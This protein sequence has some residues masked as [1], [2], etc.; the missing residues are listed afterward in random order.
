MNEPHLT[1]EKTGSVGA[2]SNENEEGVLDQNYGYKL[3]SDDP[4]WS[5][6]LEEAERYDDMMIKKWDNF[7][8][9]S[10]QDLRPDNAA[11][12]ATA[13]VE[14]VGI[15]QNRTTNGQQEHP[16]P[17]SPDNFRPSASTFIVN[18][19]WFMSLWLSI[20]VALLAGLVKQWCSKFLWDRTAP[21]CKQ[22][23]IRQAR[24]NQLIR[25][26]MDLAVY[27][28][29]VVMDTALGLFLLGLLIFLQNLS[30]LMFLAALGLT[31]LT[32]AFYFGT[33]FAPFFVSF[34]PY[35]T[36]LSSRKI[37]G[38]LFQ[39]CR[40]LCRKLVY[41]TLGIWITVIKYFRD[42]IN[43]N[44]IDAAQQDPQI[45]DYTG[46]MFACE[47][48]EIEISSKTTPDQLTG[49]ALK[50]IILH[51]QKPE[52]RETAIRAIATLESEEALTQLVSD[53]P[54]IILRVIQSFTSCFVVNDIK[55]GV[56]IGFR[57]PIDADLATL[58]GR[59]LTVLVTRILLKGDLIEPQGR[60][61]SHRGDLEAGYTHLKWA[62]DSVTKR[63]V[64]T[65]FEH[66]ANKSSNEA[67]VWA[68][69]GSSVWCDF[70]GLSGGL[71][72]NQG[73]AVCELASTLGQSLPSILRKEVLR[74]LTKEISYWAPNV[75]SRYRK[76]ILRHLIDLIPTA[77]PPEQPQLA[78][79]LVV[80]AINLN[81]GASYILLPGYLNS[82]PEVPRGEGPCNKFAEE[83]ISYYA[84]TPIELVKDEQ[85]LLLFALTGLM[86]YYEH[87]DFDDEAQQNMKKVAAR[88]QT[89]DT[90]GKL[91]S[92]KIPLPSN[93]DMT[94]DLRAYFTNTLLIYLKM[95]RTPQHCQNMDEVLTHLLKAIN[96]KRQ[97][98]ELEEYGPQIV[99]LVTQILVQTED[100]ELQTQ[101][102]STIISYWDSGPLLYSRLQLFY[103]VP[104]KL[105]RIIKD[106]GRE[107][108]SNSILKPNTSLIFQKMAEQAGNFTQRDD[109]RLVL[110]MDS[111][112]R[113]DLLEI[114][115][116]IVHLHDKI[117]PPHPQEGSYEVG[118]G[119]VVETP[120]L[121]RVRGYLK[122]KGP[123][124][125]RESGESLL[126]KMVETYREGQLAAE[127]IRR[128]QGYK[129]PK[130]DTHMA[131]TSGNA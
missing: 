45:E 108:P 9:Q 76:D 12:T 54:G 41:L 15:L 21:P 31:L 30:N 8:V 100:I 48:K 47:K 5:C 101:C 92:I 62:L 46:Y 44:N 63:A 11:I 28:L 117:V 114:L 103:Q 97:S 99:P 84:S 102:L 43:R 87:C 4:F 131:S 80:L 1:H 128:W 26:Q 81:H 29:P 52:P 113:N 88:F 78:C 86:E 115:I 98:Y 53:L 36:A 3:G 124:P 10:S 96:P 6:Y 106:K 94:I 33:T 35:E 105:L 55:K 70:I 129:R 38:L 7:L 126:K 118:S 25:L 68:L 17:N 20:T 130:D 95:P 104:L 72:F 69:V 64:K 109:G 82:Q 2:N 93:R 73:R 110:C 89:F 75:S 111:V 79:A 61:P 50:W 13:I 67:R 83:L 39:I 59:A 57:E 71:R 127:V 107:L 14:I 32:T 125:E 42:S 116:G 16:N 23:R 37:W 56:V 60:A 85:P 51:S 119:L 90:L 34:C 22:A 18:F 49:D 40:K 24:L 77:P 27:V 91:Q 58:H 120:L 19:A 66:L 121:K 122:N 112:V 123:A 65:R 74:T